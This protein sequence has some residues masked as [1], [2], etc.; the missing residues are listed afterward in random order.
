MRWGVVSL[1]LTGFLCTGGGCAR[2]PEKAEEKPFWGLF[3]GGGRM[4]LELSPQDLRLML[5]E[6]VTRNWM[7]VRWRP[8]PRTRMTFRIRR[9]AE[10]PGD[11]ECLMEGRTAVLLLATQERDHMVEQI[12]AARDLGFRTEPLVRV[13]LRINDVALDWY[14]LEAWVPEGLRLPD[15]S[16]WTTWR[17]GGDGLARTRVETS[18]GMRERFDRTFSLQSAADYQ[19]YLYRV[20]PVEALD[21]RD[22]AWFFEASS[23]RMRPFVSLQVLDRLAARMPEGLLLVMPSRDRWLDAVFDLYR[24]T[25]DGRGSAGWSRHLLDWAYG[26][27]MKASGGTVTVW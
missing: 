6:R 11:F 27:R 13:R 9:R 24:N 14:Y 8:D 23:G 10:S 16:Y 18:R 20:A 1:V 4:S 22:S 3:R 17:R 21:P 7:Q 26:A 25:G 19:V 15:G 5:G 12:G 2:G